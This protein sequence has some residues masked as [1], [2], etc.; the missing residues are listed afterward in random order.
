MHDLIPAGMLSQNTAAAGTGRAIWASPVELTCLS[1]VL[2]F[3][4][5][6]L[7]AQLM[8]TGLARWPGLVAAPAGEV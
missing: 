6:H 1:L 4:P 5:Q 8:M 7:A 2:G 3:A